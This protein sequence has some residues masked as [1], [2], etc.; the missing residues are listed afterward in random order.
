M[1]FN[2]LK[3]I[4]QKYIEKN[5]IQIDFISFEINTYDLKFT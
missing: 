1:Y 2:V 5:C 4:A 3:I